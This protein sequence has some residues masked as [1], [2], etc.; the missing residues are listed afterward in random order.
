[1]PLSGE[2]LQPKSTVVTRLRPRDIR[3]READIA[4]HNRLSELE[5]RLER[6]ESGHLTAL[7]L[8]RE[9]LGALKNT[10]TEQN[11]AQTRA[12]A[13]L[14][15]Q[16]SDCEA[17]LGRLTATQRHDDETMR[18]RL[19]DMGE[20]LEGVR[21]MASRAVKRGA[22]HKLE[23]KLERDIESR[24]RTL[25]A[26]LGER[27]IEAVEAAEGRSVEALDTLEEN[28]WEDM[29]EIAR[30]F[31]S[32][33]DTVLELRREVERPESDGAPAEA[34]P[35]TSPSPDEQTASDPCAEEEDALAET[36]DAAEPSAG[37]ASAGVIPFPPQGDGAK[38]SR[39]EIDADADGDVGTA[40]PDA[41]CFEGETATPETVEEDND[42]DAHRSF[43]EPARRLMA[44]AGSAAIALCLMGGLSLLAGPALGPSFHGSPPAFAHEGSAWTAVRAAPQPIVLTPHLAPVSG[45]PGKMHPIR[46]AHQAI[47]DR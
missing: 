12:T 42:A 9:A 27:V 16:L 43:M 2:N 15:A 46:K 8:V 11:T 17:A 29:T 23:R 38:E 44:G 13:R 34:V 24:T 3:P 40:F 5:A 7:D 10:Q 32:L 39:P 47:S 35:S 20:A 36:P 21:A 45:K 26:E 30:R 37:A 41:A 28:V 19:F 4:A 31:D 14:A 25:H 1:M 18:E 6:L 33:A 22:L